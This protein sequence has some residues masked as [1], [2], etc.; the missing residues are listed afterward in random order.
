MELSKALSDETTG[1]S[2]KDRLGRRVRVTYQ[3]Y[4]SEM[5]LCP[6]TQRGNEKVLSL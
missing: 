5:G 2:L 1:K 4:K 6:N 3:T